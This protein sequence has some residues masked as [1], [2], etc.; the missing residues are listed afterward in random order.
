MNLNQYQLSNQENTSNINPKSYDNSCLSLKDAINKALLSG[1][2]LTPPRAKNR[3]VTYGFF[4]NTAKNK[5]DIEG[6]LS[7]IGQEIAQTI[8]YKNAVNENNKTN[9]KL[10]KEIQDLISI[11][12]YTATDTGYMENGYTT[13][14]V[15]KSYNGLFTYCQ[16]FGTTEKPVSRN[17]AS[18][19]L[20]K[21]SKSRLVLIDGV[22]RGDGKGYRHKLTLNESM[23]LKV[24]EEERQ[25]IRDLGDKKM[26]AYIKMVKAIAKHLSCSVEVAKEKYK[27][28]RDIH[29]ARNYLPEWVFNKKPKWC[30]IGDNIEN[31]ASNDLR[32]VKEKHPIKPQKKVKKEPIQ[33]E[34]TVTKSESKSQTEQKSGLIT[35][36]VLSE[37]GLSFV[38]CMKNG[39]LNRPIEEFEALTGLSLPKAYQ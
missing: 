1:F 20:K 28:L 11:Y 13:R 21:L 3:V 9:H 4:Q 29:K 22:P 19:R 12:N 23:I 7:R 39:I 33:K 38:E 30:I 37:V 27:T 18:R 25:R 10:S 17:T 24:L 6:H 32:V 26:G 34:Q 15:A 35:A 5:A 16:I 36:S 2:K 8:G 31:G 14:A